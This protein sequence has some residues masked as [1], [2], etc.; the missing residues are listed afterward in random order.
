MRYVFVDEAGNFDF[1]PSGTRYFILSALTMERPFPSPQPLIDLKYD[2]W[3][4]GT[5]IEYFHASEDKQSVRDRVFAVLSTNLSH[6]RFDSVIVE[7][8]KTHRALQDDHSRFYR[9]MFDILIGYVLEGSRDSASQIIVVT[10][11]IP[12][13]KKKRQ[14]EKGIKTRLAGWAKL[15]GN[16][17]SIQHVAS[18]SDLNLQIVDYMNWAVYRRWSRHDNRSYS[19]IRPS[20]HSEFD[21]FQAG[22]VYYY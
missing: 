2:L 22:T 21:V 14:I 8:R 10:D 5:A 20:I 11:H 4:L 16:S 7:K 17:Y 6:F 3:S 19:L 15:H 13:K 18:K 1:S 9:K 12:I